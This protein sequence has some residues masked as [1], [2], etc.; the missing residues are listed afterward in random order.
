MDIIFDEKITWDGEVTITLHYADGTEVVEMLKNMVMNCSKNMVRDGLKGLVSDFKIKYV[1][2][3][4]STTAVANTQTTLGTE[5]FRKVVTQQTAGGT[6]VL[7]T[8]CYIAS[9]EANAFTIEEIGWFA[10]ANAT[11]AANSGVMVARVLYHRAKTNLESITITRTD[12][13]A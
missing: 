3:G 11:E 5:Q 2:L 7:T 9:Y 10:G 6:G 4:S 8:T 13:L 12:T 1:A